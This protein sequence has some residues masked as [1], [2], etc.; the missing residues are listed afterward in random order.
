MISPIIIM[1]RRICFRLANIPRPQLAFLPAHLARILE[2]DQQ[3]AS[4]KYAQCSKYLSR[5]DCSDPAIVKMKG[6]MLFNAHC[7]SDAFEDLKP[8]LSELIID[9]SIRSQYELDQ[10][11]K[12]LTRE[13]KINRAVGLND[14]TAKLARREEEAVE[15]QS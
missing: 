7:L 14:I 6:A 15:F 13:V 4:P 9:G 5:I 12:W 10:L 11:A 3:S 1:I 8:V 2:E